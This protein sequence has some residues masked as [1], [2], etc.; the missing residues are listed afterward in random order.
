M[1]LFT[2]ALLKKRVADDLRKAGPFET[3]GQKATRII[4]ESFSARRTD[5][6]SLTTYDIFLSHSS[7]DASLV[8]GLT[9]QIQDLGYSVYV[10][11]IDDPLLDRSKVTKQTAKLL[12]QRMKQSSC[13]IYAFSMNAV[14]SRWMP[15]ELGYFDGLKNKATVLPIVASTSNSYKGSEYLSLYNYITI[16][17]TI[18]NPS[19]QLL[20]VNEDSS[21]YTKF[22]DWLNNNSLPYKHKH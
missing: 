20:W 21:T 1:A 3:T 5:L 16:A 22:D 9:L 4:N 12:Q 2:E 17:G 19:R 13:L 14:A 7:T 15:W 10:D 18:Q 11:W 6:S 8:A